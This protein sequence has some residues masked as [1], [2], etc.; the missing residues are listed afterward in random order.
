MHIIWSKTIKMVN[1]NSGTWYSI[2]NVFFLYIIDLRTPIG[3]P[4]SSVKWWLFLYHSQSASLM[5]LI[6][7]QKRSLKKLCLWYTIFPVFM[8]LNGRM[9]F[10]QML[11]SIYFYFFPYLPSLAVFN[12][13][14]IINW[15]GQTLPIA[16]WTLDM[17]MSA[18]HL[19]AMNI[20]FFAFLLNGAECKIYL[21]QIKG[22]NNVC[23]Q[24]QLIN[25]N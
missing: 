22:K 23:Y 5:L 18:F 17:H 13:L 19:V 4:Y 3:F 1:F 14:N 21:I 16:H 2:L 25:I 12:A 9:M 24:L 8:Q 11:N 10:K 20:S 15:I 7:F 6:Q